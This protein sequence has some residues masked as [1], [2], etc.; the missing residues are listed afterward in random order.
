MVSFCLDLRSAESTTITLSLPNT[1][2]Q[3]MTWIE[4][5]AG[6][7]ALSQIE[8]DHVTEYASIVLV[9]PCETSAMPPRAGMAK[10][11]GTAK[12]SDG[13][14]QHRACKKGGGGCSH[15]EQHTH[16]DP[17]KAVAQQLHPYNCRP[18]PPTLTAPPPRHPST[19]THSPGKS[20]KRRRIKRRTRR[21]KKKYGTHHT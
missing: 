2:I 12:A 21:R 15:K 10:W 7:V 16:S 14:G 5:G 8:H 1:F 13:G 18:Q 17:R 9:V 19:A 11:A 4:G 6:G 20:C 3:C